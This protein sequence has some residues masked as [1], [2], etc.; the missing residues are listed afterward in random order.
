MKTVLFIMYGQEG[1][2][3]LMEMCTMVL[4]RDYLSGQM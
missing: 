1:Q 4:L 3:L 2:A